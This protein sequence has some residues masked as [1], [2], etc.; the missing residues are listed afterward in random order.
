VLIWQWGAGIP[1][2]LPEELA[3][4]AYAPAPRPLR[5]SRW[6]MAHH[7]TFPS[8]NKYLRIFNYLS[9]SERFSRP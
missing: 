4:E 7:P 1:S 5:W 8:F 2:A 9:W 3:A 6:T